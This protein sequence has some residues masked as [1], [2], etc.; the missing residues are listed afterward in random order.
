M[1]MQVGGAQ[2]PPTH[3]RLAQSPPPLHV[4]PAR[5]AAQAP[6][7]STSDSEPFFS[8]SSHAGAA[9]RFVVALHTWL[10]QSVVTAQVLPS[11][12]APQ[13]APPQSTSVSV[14]FLMVSAQPAPWQMLA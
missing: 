1:S 3:D 12:Q 10:M 2:V 11:G 5:Q 9:Q 13:P 8:L 7:Q 14:P 6:P 4:L